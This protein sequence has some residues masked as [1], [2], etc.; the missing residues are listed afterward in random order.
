MSSSTLLTRIMSTKMP[1][2]AF[3]SSTRSASWSHRVSLTQVLVEFFM[4]AMTV[5][6]LATVD[7][8]GLTGFQQALLFIQ[9]CIGYP[10][11]SQFEQR[12]AIINAG[13]IFPDRRF[14]VRGVYA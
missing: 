13:Y 4:G 9:M 7:L 14:L 10:V 11:R 8:S 6:G 1:R 5:C 3:S 12:N 2:A